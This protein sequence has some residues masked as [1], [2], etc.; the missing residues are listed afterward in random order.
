MG[1]ISAASE[2]ISTQIHGIGVA[3]ELRFLGTQ[4]RA[5]GSDDQSSTAGILK[6][7]H[8]LGRGGAWDDTRGIENFLHNG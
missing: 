3:A 5:T 6:Q 8:L 7:R 4:L 1:R 2:P